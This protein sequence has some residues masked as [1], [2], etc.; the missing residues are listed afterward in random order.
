MKTQTENKALQREREKEKK[1]LI[2]E[3]E[4]QH[5]GG[6]SGGESTQMSLKA[7]MTVFFFC[8]LTNRQ[9][10]R[11]TD[12]HRGGCTCRDRQLECQ[13]SKQSK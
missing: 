6:F 7:S 9:T 8:I 11:E 12:G 1:I 10:D 3:G 4:R 2:G 13:L 5:F